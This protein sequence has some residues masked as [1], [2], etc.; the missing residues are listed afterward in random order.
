MFSGNSPFSRGGNLACIIQCVSSKIEICTSGNKIG[1]CSWEGGQDGQK[2]DRKN[3]LLSFEDVMSYLGIE[4]ERRRGGWETS[5]FVVPLN[6][7]FFFNCFHQLSSQ[8][9]LGC[10]HNNL[11]GFLITGR[12]WGPEKLTYLTQTLSF[13]A[14][15]FLNCG[16]KIL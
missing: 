12:V 8:Y 16:V 9:G 1:G 13:S 5:N 11:Q 4:V 10:M 2:R 6:S 7:L 3:I 15:Y 14:S